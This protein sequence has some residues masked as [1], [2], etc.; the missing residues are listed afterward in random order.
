[1][2]KLR[3]KSLSHLSKVPEFRMTKARLAPTVRIVTVSPCYYTETSQVSGGLCLTW[4]VITFQPV[5]PFPFP[6]C[7]LPSRFASSPLPGSVSFRV[8]LPRCPIIQGALRIPSWSPPDS[9]H[10]S[11]HEEPSWLS[12]IR[13]IALSLVE[14]LLSYAWTM[15]PIHMLLSQVSHVLQPSSS[16]S[17]ILYPIW[18]SLLPRH[19][20]LTT[21]LTDFILALPTS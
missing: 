8:L 18:L 15:H 19:R 11:V 16:L 9:L 2:R 21:S 5:E 6:F 1:M 12:G 13:F 14:W 17:H 4:P 20:S 7:L 10:V 3:H